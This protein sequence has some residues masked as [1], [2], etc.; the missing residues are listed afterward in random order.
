MS[1]YISATI[2]GHLVKSET[3]AAVEGSCV[4]QAKWKL[5]PADSERQKWGFE[6]KID[7]RNAVGSVRA[8]APEFDFDVTRA[9]SNNHNS[10][11][12][13]QTFHDREVAQ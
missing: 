8:V 7:L 4:G 13:H 3:L 11:N 2:N 12:F 10:L 1:K 5:V 9:S 6:V